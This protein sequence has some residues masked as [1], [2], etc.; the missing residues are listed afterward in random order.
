M[1]LNKIMFL[2]DVM[3]TELSQC[4]YDIVLHYTLYIK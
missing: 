4:Y 2:S 3:A 1:L